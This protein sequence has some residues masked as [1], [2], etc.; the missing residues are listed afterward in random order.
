MNI[1][2]EFELYKSKG[3][4]IDLSRGRPSK[5]QLDL[6]LP[7]MDILSSSSDYLSSGVDTRNYGC[8]EGLK[9]CRDLFSPIIGVPSNNIIIMGNS[10]INIMYDQISRSMFFGVCGSTPWSKLEKI[11]WLCP[12]PGYDRHFSILEHFGIEMIPIHMNE[13]GPDIEE[14][15]KYISDESVKGLW[16]VPKYS[17]PS[18]ITY[19]DEVVRRLAR[20]SPKVKDFRIYWDYAYAIHDFDEETKLLN[21]YEEAKRNG[22]EDIVYLF[23]STSKVT[24]PG[25]GISMIG[26]SERNINDIKSHLTIQTIGYDKINQLRHVRFFKTTDGL[27]NHMKKHGE[28]LKR[29]FDIVE[30]I[31]SRNLNG[32]ASWSHPKGGYFVLLE[33]KGIASQVVERCKECGVVLTSAGAT[34]PYHKDPSNSYIRIAPSSLSDEDLKTAMQVL[35]LAVKMEHK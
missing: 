13:D 9:E 17:N 18:G 32:L 29:K 26:A 31:L 33:V 27:K 21:I 12:V 14:I 30:S 8:L 11:K 15:E 4:H 24:F 5:E 25:S 23:A 20:L 3:L 16:C 34:H 1:K 35:C 6:S 28:I 10:S 2:E 22:N 19:S 7:M